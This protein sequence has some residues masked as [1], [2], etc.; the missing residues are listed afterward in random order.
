MSQH[1]KQFLLFLKL[2]TVHFTIIYYF[3]YKDRRCLIIFLFSDCPCAGRMPPGYIPD[4]YNN[5]LPFAPIATNGQPFPWLQ[6]N[7][8]NNVRPNRYM[9]TIHPNLTT[10]D[11]KGKKIFLFFK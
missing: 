11:V 9:L 1:V 6:Q 5:S 2:F 4:Y 3:N 8:P 7:L 10:L